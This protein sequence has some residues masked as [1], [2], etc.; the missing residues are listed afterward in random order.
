MHQ[1]RILVVVDVE[2]AVFVVGVSGGRVGIHWKAGVKDLMWWCDCRHTFTV[3]LLR[4]TRATRNLGRLFTDVS[5]YSNL[6]VD[7]EEETLPVHSLSGKPDFFADAFLCSISAMPK[8]GI[9]APCSPGRI[10][11]NGGGFACLYGGGGLG[12]VPKAFRRW[13]VDMKEPK[14]DLA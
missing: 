13:L 5:K 14:M 3:L 10:F 6:P 1:Q 8:L 9:L 11:G 7:E 12:D 4:F 2:S